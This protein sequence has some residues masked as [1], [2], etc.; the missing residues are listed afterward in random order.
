MNNQIKMKINGKEVITLKDLFPKEGHLKGLIIGKRPALVSVDQGHYFQGR[1]G[2][3]F[4]NKMKDFKIIKVPNGPYEDDY[5]LANGLGIT[6]IVKSPDNYGNEPSADEY[7]QGTERILEVIDKYNPKV[8]IFV[9]KKV[10]D[11]ILEYKFNIKE[12]AT[13]GFNENRK[14][15]FN[16]EVFVF[17]MPGT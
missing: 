4:W 10:L 3:I 5:L 7:K 14:D 13:Y 9:Y 15:L 6:D 8:I 2:K 16:A 11:K 1:Q 17:P 12:K